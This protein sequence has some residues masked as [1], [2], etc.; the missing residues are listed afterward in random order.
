[1]EFVVMCNMEFVVICNMAHHSCA[2]KVVNKK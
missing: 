1:M 2:S